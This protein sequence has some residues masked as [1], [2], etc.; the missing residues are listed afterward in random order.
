[1]VVGVGG[2]D[3]DVDATVVEGAFVGGDGGVAASEAVDHVADVGVVCGVQDGPVA[4]DRKADYGFSCEAVDA[5]DMDDEV[6]VIFAPVFVEFF[7][8]SHE[9][10][11]P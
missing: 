6:G 10:S 4:G 8:F 7:G 2:V 9:I 3:D 1:M 11:L 5:A